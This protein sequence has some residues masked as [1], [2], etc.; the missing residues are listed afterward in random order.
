MQTMVV[1]TQ[2]VS[3]VTPESNVRCERNRTDGKIT[4]RQYSVGEQVLATA[5]A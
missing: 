5:I 2:K 1:K 3:H 4:K